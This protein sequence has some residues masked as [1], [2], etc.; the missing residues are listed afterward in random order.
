MAKRPRATCRVCRKPW[1]GR[2]NADVVL[3]VSHAAE[4][5]LCAGSGL[6]AIETPVIDTQQ[7]E[8]GGLP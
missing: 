7:P 6:P 8:G 3:V 4:D 1:R 5:G 2:W